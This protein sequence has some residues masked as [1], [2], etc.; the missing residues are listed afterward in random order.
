MI[1]NNDDIIIIVVVLIAI[2]YYY[3]FFLRGGFG[4]GVHHGGPRFFLFAGDFPSNV[5]KYGKS[6]WKSE[7][8]LEMRGK[9]RTTIRMQENSRRKIQP[10]GG[11]HEGSTE[12][13]EG[14]KGI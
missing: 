12:R 9:Q 10:C 4:I 8:V 14:S 1:V 3:L 5:R 13:R 11:P 7:K 2:C 6:A